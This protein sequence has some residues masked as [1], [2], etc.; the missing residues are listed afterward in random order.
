[1]PPGMGPSAPAP[2]PPS[3][4]GPPGYSGRRG[5]PSGAPAPAEAVPVIAAGQG[6]R[7][8]VRKVVAL[9]SVPA[10]DL[11]SSLGQLLRAEAEA[12]PHRATQG[13]SIVAEPVGNQLVLG[14][15]A[16]A[17]EEI[18]GLVAQLDRSAAM[19]VLDV[20][21]ADAPMDQTGEAAVT[22][23]SKPAGGAGGGLRVVARPEKMEVLAHAR[24]AVLAGL[25]AH[26][27]VGGQKGRIS[28]TTL[29]KAGQV[30]MI[31]LTSV[32][33]GVQI[34]PKVGP[35]GLVQMKIEVDSSG[36]GPTEEG[37]PISISSK[38]E[39]VRAAATETL[40]AKATVR[41]PAG[42]TIVLAEGT[43]KPRSA[44][45]RL[46]LITAQV[47]PMSGR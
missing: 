23:G 42:Q 15:P 26:L 22:P 18:V 9:K 5:R 14:G 35:D 32:G 3:G 6:P 33:T 17:V 24:L 13:V 29:T 8:H 44:K 38:G 21:L 45:Q 36:S 30:N 11:A 20:V 4:A 34:T 31:D 39:V 40:S 27:Q 16:A 43:P 7:A 28:G 41:V 46:V 47:L 37:P 25:S 10:V 2:S 1:M 19:V 12:M